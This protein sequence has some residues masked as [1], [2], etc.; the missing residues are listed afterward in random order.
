MLSAIPF[1]FVGTSQCYQLFL[2]ILWGPVNV[3][4]YSFS[5]CRD[6]SM[7]SAIPFH[8]VGTSQCYQLFLFTLWGPVNVISYSF[9]LCGDQSMLSAIPFHFVVLSQFKVASCPCSLWATI[10]RPRLVWFGLV[11][12]VLQQQKLSGLWLQPP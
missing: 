1:H 12:S 7:L 10:N 3:I 5:F 6:Q 4:S 9:S 8:F 11:L 2:F